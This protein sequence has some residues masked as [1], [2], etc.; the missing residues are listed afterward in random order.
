MPSFPSPASMQSPRPSPIVRSPARH[1]LNGAWRLD[2]F[3]QPGGVAE[4]IAPRIAGL[5]YGDAVALEST[6]AEARWTRLGST[7]S[8]MGPTP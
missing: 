1:S 6:P 7:P 2:F 5:A 3:P 8:P 4:I